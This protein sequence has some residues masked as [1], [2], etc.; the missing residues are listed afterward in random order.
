MAKNVEGRQIA[1]F[2][3]KKVWIGD[4]KYSAKYFPHPVPKL[5]MNKFKCH[6]K[7]KIQLL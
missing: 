6:N 2:A 3:P 4:K 7:L 5:G 1:H